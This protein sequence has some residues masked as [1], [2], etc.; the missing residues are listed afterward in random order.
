MSQ[1][2][3]DAEWLRKFADSIWMVDGFT[4]DDGDRL[5]S[6]ADRLERPGVENLVTAAKNL[7]AASSHFHSYE[8]VG[9]GVMRQ[10][11]IHTVPILELTRL[12][13]AVNELDPVTPAAT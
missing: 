8:P 3:T 12:E 11:A 7:I 6:I 9:G 1:E 5:R 13:G 4:N 2:L 10:R